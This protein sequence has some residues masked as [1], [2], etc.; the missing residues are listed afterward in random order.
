MPRLL[1][2]DDDPI[3]CQISRA[4]FT[5]KGYDVTTAMDGVEGL[6]KW[7]SE[8]YDLVITDLMM[9]NRHGYE[10]IDMIKL[11]A[12]GAK[13]PVI[14]LT[15]DKSEPELEKYDRRQFQ[16]D[17]LTKPFDMPMLEKMIKDLLAE[18]ADREG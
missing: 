5:S 9:P 4:Y 7:K 3:I 17:T 10:V 18:F 6:N 2:I 15:A 16:D 12:R 13:T 8:E 14:L 11:S 1:V